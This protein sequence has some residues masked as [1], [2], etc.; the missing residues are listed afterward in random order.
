MNSAA[1]L[2]DHPLLGVEVEGPVDELAHL[3]AMTRLYAEQRGDDGGRDTGPEVLHVVK[4]PAAYLR[5]EEGGAEFPDFA[6]EHG[7]AA[8]REGLG[9]QAAEPGVVGGI[10]E[11]HHA[12]D[13]V[14]AHDLEH[15]AMGRAERLGIAVGGVDVDEPA[16][17]VEVVRRGCNRPA[18][19][20]AGA[21]TCACG[22]S[23]YRSL[24]GSHASGLSVRVGLTTSPTA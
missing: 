22:S 18:P 6:F 19:R 2:V 9:H 3:F 12:A 15:G 1:D 5:I 16:Q 23:L 11:D 14:R 20:H 8:W 10:R 24:M 4:G 13:D 7:H 17:G 21:A